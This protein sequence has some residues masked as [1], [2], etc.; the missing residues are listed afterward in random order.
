MEKQQKNERK[1]NILKK[2]S[3]AYYSVDLDNVTKLFIDQ[4]QKNIL[5]I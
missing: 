2:M 3:L 1:E 5:I 4:L